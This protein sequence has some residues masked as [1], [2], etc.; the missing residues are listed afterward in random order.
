MELHG[1]SPWAIGSFSLRIIPGRSVVC[2]IVFPRKICLSPNPQN[3]WMWLSMAMGSLQMELSWGSWGE[4]TLDI[5]C[6]QPVTGVLIRQK[7][8][9]MR[10][11]GKFTWR[12]AY[13]LE[14]CGHEPR[15]G[16]NCWSYQ[17]LEERPGMDSSSE[18]PGGINLADTLHPISGLQN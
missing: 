5:R 2:W 17:K 18:L 7:R 16:K 3:P 8:G 6:L 4:L 14:Q 9:R 10:H 11:R 12:W 1:M 13:R 15:N